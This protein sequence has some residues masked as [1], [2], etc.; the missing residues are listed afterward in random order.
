MLSVQTS[1]LP[2]L[3]EFIAVNG[4]YFTLMNTAHIV[5]L[6][7]EVGGWGIEHYVSGKRLTFHIL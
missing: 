4:V 2:G 7:N 5:A 1:H 3:K 6:D